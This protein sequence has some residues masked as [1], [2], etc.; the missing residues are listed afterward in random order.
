[1]GAER[2]VEV[3]APLP[4]LKAEMLCDHGEHEHVH[5]VDDPHWWHSIDCWQRAARDVATRLGAVDK[6]HAG[7]YLARAM[8]VRGELEKLD[9]W[10]RSE[11]AK[12]PEAHRTL[13]TAHAAF[14]YFCNE[15][16]WRMLPVQGLNREQVAAPKFAGEVEV[17]IRREQVLAVFPEQ[18]SNP[19]MLKALAENLGNKIGEP[20]LAD[21]GVSIEKMFRHNVNAIVAALGT[22][23]P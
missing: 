18:H 22:A 17:V 1:V 7:E 11:L 20:L 4:T 9:G 5:E 2:V 14:A 16:G 12:V 21:G 23:Q 8:T 3:G 13:A 15:Y 10:V 19:K 6:D